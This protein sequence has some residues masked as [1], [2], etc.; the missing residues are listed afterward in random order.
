M[1]SWILRKRVRPSISQS[2]LSTLFKG[3]SLKRTSAGCRLSADFTFEESKVDFRTVEEILCHPVAQNLFLRFL[4]TNFAEENF[5][6]YKSVSKFEKLP[7]EKLCT[8]GGRI[9]SQFIEP[10]SSQWINISAGT[11]RDIL[12]TKEFKNTTFD[13]AK[14]EVVDLLRANFLDRFKMKLEREKAPFGSYGEERSGTCVEVF[15]PEE[16]DNDYFTLRKGS[17]VLSPVENF[18][19]VFPST[20]QREN[21]GAEKA[22]VLVQI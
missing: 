7:V 3:S 1:S 6:F 12:S 13:A 15:L 19:A 5:H 11:T 9:V 16:T 10:N 4:E 8:E 18:D 22:D 20:K 21:P 17:S 14:F 2:R